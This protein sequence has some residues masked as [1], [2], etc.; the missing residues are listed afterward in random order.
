MTVISSFFAMKTRPFSKFHQNS[1]WSKR[2][3]NLLI[4]TKDKWQ[5][6]RRPVLY[7]LTFT[8]DKSRLSVRQRHL[9][10]GGFS[11]GYVIA[12]SEPADSQVSPFSPTRTTFE[13]G[14][15]SI[16]YVIAISEPADSQAHL[17]VRQGLVQAW[18]LLNW[19]R[20]CDL[21]TGR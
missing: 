5:T 19:L 3:L 9:E 4:F 2:C 1:D 20:H 18:W 17:S 16:G 11:I 13:L 15:F 8:K 10:F 7:L 14:G 21:W 12:T 6:I